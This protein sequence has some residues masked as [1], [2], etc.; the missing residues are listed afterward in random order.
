MLTL[1]P[2]RVNLSL[3]AQLECCALAFSVPIMVVTS[4]HSLQIHSVADVAGNN[5]W[6]ETTLEDH[7]Q[8]VKAI[9]ERFFAAQFEES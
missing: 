6:S 7:A 4:S 1:D 5:G 9:N 3:D 8:A 2:D